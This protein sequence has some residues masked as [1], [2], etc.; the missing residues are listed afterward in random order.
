MN[1]AAIAQTR[2]CGNVAPAAAAT[3]G[4]TMAVVVGVSDYPFVTPLNYAAD[5][6]LLM[7]EFLQSSAGGNVPRENI[8]LL[9]NDEATL[10]GVVIQG[11]SWLENTMKPTRGDRVIIYLA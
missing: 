7:Y 9:L 2:G 11:M 8:K 10:Q 3:G 1:V 6:A 5:D 4:R